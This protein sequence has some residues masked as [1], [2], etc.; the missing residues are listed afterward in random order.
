MWKVELRGEILWKVEI[1]QLKW[2][3]EIG[4]KS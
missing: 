2:K 3:V 4:G 1:E